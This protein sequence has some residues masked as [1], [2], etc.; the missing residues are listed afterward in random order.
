MKATGAGKAHKSPPALTS[1]FKTNKN[2]RLGRNGL[3]FS[4]LFF[5]K[6]GITGVRE[7]MSYL[8]GWDEFRFASVGSYS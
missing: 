6:L 4:S 7:I 3:L 1:D 5:F 8:G 2:L